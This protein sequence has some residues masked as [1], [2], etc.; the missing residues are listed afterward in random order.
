[1]K[2]K[3]A[4]DVNDFLQTVEECD[5]EVW[6]ESNYGDKYVLK[7]LF[8]RYIALSALLSEQGDRLELYCQLPEDRTKFYKYFHEHPGVN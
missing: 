6:L 4:I 7:S 2:F 8:S 5:G 1:M 3:N